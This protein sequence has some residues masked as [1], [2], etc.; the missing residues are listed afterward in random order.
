MAT[1]AQAQAAVGLAAT[2]LA[3][4][5]RGAARRRARRTSSSFNVPDIGKTPVRRGV[6]PRRRRSP[7]SRRSSTPRCSARS[8]PRASTTMRV[9]AFALFNEMLA[10]PAR[11]GFTNATDARVRSHAVAALHVGEPRRRR[12]AAQTFV[13]ADGVHPTT[14]GHA[15]IAQAVAVDDHRSAADGG[16]GRSAARRRAGEFPRARQPHV[17]EPQCAAQPGQAPGLGGLRLQHT[18]TCRRDR[19]TAAAHMNTIAVGGD[20]K[21]SDRML[22]GAHV[23]LHRQQGRLRRRRRRIHAEAAGR[24]ASTRAT[25]TARGTSARRF[26]AGGLDYSDITR[27]I[28]LGAALRTESADARGYE[29]TGRDPR[30]LLVHDA[31]LDARSVRARS[32]GRRP[33]SSSFPRRARTARR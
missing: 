15:L 2:Q 7:R 26:G 33:S 13:F 1:P 21:V 30:R 32:R 19:P 28:P 29:F 14:A 3:Q 20:M 6:R 4:A 18:R 24:H 27:V 25:A 5:D 31:G 12:S 10:N 8:T 9:N 11:Y 22:A 16:A 17:V 23:R